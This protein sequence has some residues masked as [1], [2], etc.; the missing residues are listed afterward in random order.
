[1]P[2]P[3]RRTPAR[4][5]ALTLAFGLLGAACGLSHAQAA[6]ERSSASAASSA[7]VA[8]AAPALTPSRDLPLIRPPSTESPAAPYGLQAVWEQGDPVARATLL[9]LLIMSMAS[10]YVLVR[11]LI[12][13]ARMRRL[14]RSATASLTDAKSLRE[15]ANLLQPGSP[16]RFIAE[17]SMA[18]LQQ[19]D[20]VAAQVDLNMW[21]TQNIERSVAT[22]QS[23]SQD[24]LAVLATVG[25]NRPV[26]RPVWHGLGHLPRAGQDR[27]IR[28]GLDRPGGGAGWR[29]PDH[30][31]HRAGR[32][33]AR[34]A[35]LQLARAA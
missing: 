4:L 31:R 9:I 32:C 27:R 6:A 15:A 34:G 24:G 1:M 17:S 18:S 25:C 7:P 11:K 3:D 2:D 12:E 26:R 22:V 35:G 28:T 23:R 21:L 20:T 10:W 19:H 29:G 8:I 13:Q 14:A 16:F 30:D 33:G 5:L